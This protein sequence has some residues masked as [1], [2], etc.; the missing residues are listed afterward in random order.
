M[1]LST[2]TRAFAAVLV[3]SSYPFWGVVRA[4]AQD[5]EHL[6]VSSRINTHIS[7]SFERGQYLVGPGDRFVLKVFDANELSG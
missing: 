4:Y 7:S 6:S 5:T 3:A 1:Q 2:I